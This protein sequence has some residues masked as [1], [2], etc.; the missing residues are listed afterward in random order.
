MDKVNERLDLAHDIF[1]RALADPGAYP[2]HLIVI[3]LS[4]LAEG[5][6]LSPARL[7]TLIRLRKMGGYDR[8]QDLA[9]DLGRGKHRVSKDISALAGL[10]LVHKQ[11]HG[12][13]M[14]IEASGRPIMLVD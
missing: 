8:L 4:L 5:A 9:D 12:R 13:Q 6:V 7:E 10:G 14:H 3:P 2:E 11:R 1:Q